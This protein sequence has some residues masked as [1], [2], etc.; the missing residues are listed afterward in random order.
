MFAA[1]DEVV[2]ATALPLMTSFTA[3]CT[4]RSMAPEPMW[5]SLK[6][7][8]HSAKSRFNAEWN[9]MRSPFVRDPTIG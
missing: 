4:R 9:I 2:H 8:R 1:L 7:A 3:P 6:T 5:R